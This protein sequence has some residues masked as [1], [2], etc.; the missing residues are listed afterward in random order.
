MPTIFD[1]E[2]IHLSAESKLL[3]SPVSIQESQQEKE[4]LSKISFSYS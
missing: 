1:L 3:K 2:K 4:F